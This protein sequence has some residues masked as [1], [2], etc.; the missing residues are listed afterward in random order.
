MD[1]S[2][3][4]ALFLERNGE[5]VDQ[6]KYIKTSGAMQKMQSIMERLVE[7]TPDI[8]KYISPDSVLKPSRSKYRTNFQDIKDNISNKSRFFIQPLKAE[9]SA[10]DCIKHVKDIEI[11][12]L[13][14]K[15]QKKQLKDELQYKKDQFV[16]RELDYRK[17][18][19][20]YQD[21]IRSKALLNFIDIPDLEVASNTHKKILQYIEDTQKNTSK[22]LVDQEST[23]LRFFNNK[24]NEIKKQFEEERVKKGKKDQDYKEKESQLIHELDW[25]KNIAQ[26]IDN[27]NHNLQKKY[28]DLKAQ[29]Q[30]QENDRQM[31]IKIEEEIKKVQQLLRKEQKN[32]RELK[33][34]YVQ[35]LESKNSLEKILRKCIEDIKEQIL[36]FKGNNRAIIKDY[37]TEEMKENRD[38]IIERLINDEK[39]LTLI[40]DHTFYSET[41]NIDTQPL[42]AD[43]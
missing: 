7:N 5:R 36:Q 3:D 30:T 4:D 40:Y 21:Q 25:I 20:D 34:L 12:L 32:A 2:Q 10:A 39:I 9:A 29:Y 16:K 38:K 23:I 24:I 13:E 6:T 31:L 27:E 42:Q 19:Q 18:I 35:Q 41:K 22:I 8:Q 26:K 28:M 17:I 37:E 33:S 15:E 11:K 1:D 43:Y 14:I